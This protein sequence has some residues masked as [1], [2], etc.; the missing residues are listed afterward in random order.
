MEH[1]IS[2]SLKLFGILYALK[3]FV[4]KRLVGCFLGHE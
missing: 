2:Q 1:Y 4:P 3:E